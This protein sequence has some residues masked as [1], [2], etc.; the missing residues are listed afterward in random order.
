MKRGAE[1][2]GRATFSFPNSRVGLLLH[3][4]STLMGRESRKLL[5]EPP[6]TPTPI[7]PSKGT[8]GLCLLPYQV[9]DCFLFSAGRRLTLKQ[10][11]VCKSN[12]QIV[13]HKPL[14]HSRAHLGTL[15]KS[16]SHVIFSFFPQVIKNWYKKFFLMQWWALPSRHIG[17]ALPSTNL[18]KWLHVSPFP[19]HFPTSCPKYGYGLK[20]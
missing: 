4:L 10:H 1:E 2:V 8:E 9:S 18:S 15:P 13:Q 12:L 20:N 16:S 3:G 19:G 17:P 6:T 5:S 14:E 11:S 7:T